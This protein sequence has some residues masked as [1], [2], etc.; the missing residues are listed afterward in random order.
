M[1]YWHWILVAC[2]DNVRPVSCVENNYS[3]MGIMASQITGINCLFNVQGDIK[4]IIKAP[5]HCPMARESTVA[6]WF[7]AQRANNAESV[8]MSWHLHALHENISLGISVW[9]GQDSELYCRTMCL[10]LSRFTLS[11]VH[12]LL[13]CQELLLWNVFI[14]HVNSRTSVWPGLKNLNVSRLVLELTLHSQLKP[15][16]KSRMKIYLEQRR[17][18]MLQLHL[19][20]PQF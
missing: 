13:L 16:V 5:R 20:D 14:I 19:N 8:P 7:P 1:V 15:G 9:S 10:N 6:S 2:H 17:Q 4:R 12:A 3:H 18:A 11:S